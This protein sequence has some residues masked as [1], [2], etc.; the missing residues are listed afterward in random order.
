MF[1]ELKKMIVTNN[2]CKNKDFFYGVYTFSIILDRMENI[3]MSKK[4]MTEKSGERQPHAVLREL[5]S[6]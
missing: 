3:R 6:H 1:Q 5:H 2:M 4:D